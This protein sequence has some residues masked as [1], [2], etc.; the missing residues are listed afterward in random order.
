MLRHQL[1]AAR[2]G[3]PAPGMPG[4]QHAGPSQQP[5]SIAPGNGLF[6]GIMAGGN[7]QGLAPPQQH[8]PPQDQQM[9]PQHQMAQG[10][11]AMPGPPHP[12]AQQAAYG[13][14]PQ[15]PNGM[16][17]QAPPGTASPGPRGRG[18]GRPP[19]GPATPQINTP[20]PYPP[21]ASPQVSHPTPD[22]RMGGAR[23]VGNALGDLE[24]ETVPPQ[25]K[26]HGSDWHAVFNP[27]VQRVLDVDLVHSLTHESVVCCV[28]FSH[29][30]KYV[31][32]GCNRS[33][34]I[35]D[36]QTG[37]KVCVL[38]DH[39]AQDMTADLYIR[40][41]CFSPDG[42]YL[43]TGAEDKVIRVSF[44][45]VVCFKSAN[46]NLVRFGIFT[47]EPF[48]TTSTVTSKTFTRSTL[49]ATD[50]R[51]LPALATEPSDFGT[52]RMVPTR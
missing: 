22:T 39:N 44:L 41:V 17:P 40:S 25:Y 16:G 3:Q 35:F 51:L 9:G 32:T 33:A 50:A 21:N 1:D 8:A 38:E 23:G 5:P 37:E 4:P 20:A 45:V 12:N 30:G 43:A 19:V 13:G 2:K 47:R 31:A 28:R 26:K 10:P 15:G 7:Q 14:Y 18:V 24:V 46:A 29:D 42:R 48:A 34:Q 52:L 49:L 11:P 6:S 36:V 27:A